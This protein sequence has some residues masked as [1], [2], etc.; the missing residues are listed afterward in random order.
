MSTRRLIAFALTPLA[1]VSVPAPAQPCAATDLFPAHTDHGRFLNTLQAFA[2]DVNGDGFADI[3]A[4]DSADWSLEVYLN[5]GAGGFGVA[6]AGAYD[7]APTATFLVVADFN[8]DG[9]HDVVTYG[10]AALELGFM[11]GL[12]GGAFGAAVPFDAGST[13]A[14]REIITADFN[15]DGHLDLAVASGRNSLTVL[16]GTGAG[17][18]SSPTDWP[19]GF[20]FPVAH[21][22]RATDLNADNDPDLVVAGSNGGIDTVVVLLGGPGATFAPGMHTDA[23]ISLQGVAVGDLNNDG[24]PDVVSVGILGD[25]GVSLGLGGAALAAT[26]EHPTTLAPRDVHIAD[27]NNDGNA[28]VLIGADSISSAAVLLGAGDGTLSAETLIPTALRPLYI[29]LADLNN[30]STLDLI[31]ANA[32]STD[33]SVLLNACPATPAGCNDADLAPPFGTLDF[34][35]VLEFLTAFASMDPAADLAPPPGVWDFSDVLAFL[36]AFGAG[37]P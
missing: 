4:C 22:V 31:T 23:P 16:T 2:A 18:F 20:P 13:S 17:T 7:T 34:S 1:L 15:Q 26:V 30:D 36:A 5:D 9:I 28:D 8:E 33:F 29:T 27:V 35:D 19:L 37:C 32:Q 3:L 21:G 25:V 14:A 10:G 12:G 6:P 24:L 11:P